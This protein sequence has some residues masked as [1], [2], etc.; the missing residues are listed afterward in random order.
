ML[1]FNLFLLI[2]EYM[3]IWFVRWWIKK[4]V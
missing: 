3:L 4:W 2:R 1:V